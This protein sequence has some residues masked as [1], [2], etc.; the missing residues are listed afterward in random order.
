LFSHLRLCFGLCGD[1]RRRRNI[2]NRG[3][4]AGKRARWADVRPRCRQWQLGRSLS[5]YLFDR[6]RG[7]EELFSEDQNARNAEA[8]NDAAHQ[9]AQLGAPSKLRA[10]NDGTIVHFLGQRMVDAR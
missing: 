1:W 9:A 5:R 3:L 7:K 4:R 6:R 10:G 8:S 2:F